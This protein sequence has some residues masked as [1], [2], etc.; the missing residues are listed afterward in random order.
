MANNKIHYSGDSSEST[1]VITAPWG[2][3][4]ISWGAVFAGLVVA[5]AVHIALNI[6]G[7]GIGMGAID[8]VADRQPL[9]G[10]GVG[11]MI[12]YALSLLISLFLGGYVAGRLAGIPRTMASVMHGVL[13]WALFT[14]VSVY[15]LAATV[16]GIVGGVTGVAGEAVSMA[17]RGI[18]AVAPNIS[19]QEAARLAEEA[20]R[21]T[22]QA[23]SQLEQPETEARVRR[24]ADDIR[25][26]ISTA[27]IFAFIGMLLGAGAAA[28]G[29]KVGEPQDI[30]A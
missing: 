26:A 16:G 6:L 7:L 18:S 10:L 28:W 14:I 22:Q 3:K 25:S 27:A 21:V 2:F 23:Q 9:E 1:G 20:E 30:L 13:T 8:P 29:G 15:I 4:K 24:T 19:E 5:I 12:W 17:S 11:T